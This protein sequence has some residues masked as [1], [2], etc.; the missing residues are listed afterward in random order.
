[1]LNYEIVEYLKKHLPWLFNGEELN[2]DNIGKINEILS[3]APYFKNKE[4]K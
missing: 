3:I 1:M 4:N 2:I